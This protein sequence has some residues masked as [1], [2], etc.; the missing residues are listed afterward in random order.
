MANHAT[1]QYHEEQVVC[2]SSLR[3]NLFTTAAVDNIDHNLSSTTATTSFHGTGISLF[4]QPSTSAQG[5]DRR[6]EFDEI[7]ESREKRRHPLPEFYTSVIPACY[8]KG[9][10]FVPKIHR[11]KDMRR[12][13]K[14]SDV[15]N[16]SVI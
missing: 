9:E 6:K 15:L 4:Q 2:P 13:D 11:A 10:I 5:I 1:S 8:K 16:I 3:L 12:G 14:V 7:T